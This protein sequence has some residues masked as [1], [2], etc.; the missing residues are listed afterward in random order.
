MEVHCVGVNKINLLSDFNLQKGNVTDH[1]FQ[2]SVLSDSLFEVT[3][4][5]NV[6]ICMEKR[7]RCALEFIHDKL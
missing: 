3:T 1:S 5:R 7:K 4:P 2:K 6:H